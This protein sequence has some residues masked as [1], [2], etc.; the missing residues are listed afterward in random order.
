[1]LPAPLA[2]P[3]QV[4][5]EKHAEKKRDLGSEDP[6]ISGEPLRATPQKFWATFTVTVPASHPDVHYFT[7][8][9]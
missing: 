9:F 5:P 6:E 1:M 3:I 8:F 2:K 7:Y 4:Q